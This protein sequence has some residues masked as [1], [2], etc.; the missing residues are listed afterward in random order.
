VLLHGSLVLVDEAAED[1]P[2]PDLSRP[3]GREE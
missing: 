2:A 1:S 3:E